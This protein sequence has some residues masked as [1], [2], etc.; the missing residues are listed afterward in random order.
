MTTDV[1]RDEQMALGEHLIDDPELQHL[2]ET[3]RDKDTV[4]KDLAKQ[5][6]NLKLDELKDQ[7]KAKLQDYGISDAT[8]P[9]RFRLGDT[10]LV[11]KVT[12]PGE[13]KDAS[14]VS[15]PRMRLSLELPPKETE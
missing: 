4:R 2:A 11:V 15:Q 8:E 13:A 12:P 14:F 7:L 5:I 10:G 1:E 9:M 3:W 6:K